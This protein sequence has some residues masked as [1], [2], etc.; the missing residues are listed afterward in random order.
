MRTQHWPL[1]DLQS[2]DRETRKLINGNGQRHPLSSTAVLY[3]PRDK[4]GRGL[5]S[6][7]QEYKLIKTKMAMRLYE[8]PDSMMRSVWIFE[9]KEC[10]KGFSTLVKDAHKFAEKLA[11]CVN[12]ATPDPSLSSQQVPEKRISKYQVS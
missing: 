10:E 6:I 12:L 3:L 2:I 8:N 4:S 7:E 1:G 11:T 9:D 5:K